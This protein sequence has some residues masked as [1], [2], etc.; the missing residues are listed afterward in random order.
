MPPDRDPRVTANCLANII[1][2]SMILVLIFW[3]FNVC[4]IDVLRQIGP[5]SIHGWR[6]R[7]LLESGNMILQIKEHLPVT[8]R[9]NTTTFHSEQ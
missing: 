8:V 6:I 9:Q 5:S 1:F 4:R 3:R 2:L 7:V